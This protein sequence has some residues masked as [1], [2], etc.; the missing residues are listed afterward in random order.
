MFVGTILRHGGNNTS[1]TK[2]QPLAAIGSHGGGGYSPPGGDA[3]TPPRSPFLAPPPRSPVGLE[4]LRIP[5]FQ[6][7]EAQRAAW[8]GKGDFIL[9]DFS[10][11][12]FRGS[13][14]S[15]EG[16]EAGDRA[17]VMYAGGESK[18]ECLWDFATRTFPHNAREVSKGYKASMKAFGL[19][20][21]AGWMN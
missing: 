14:D 2:Q 8:V 15:A 17:C 6:H 13:V 1:R 5:G 21:S 12:A 16:L 11:M 3:V 19:L 20:R 7:R 10:Q 4:T 9:D 18:D